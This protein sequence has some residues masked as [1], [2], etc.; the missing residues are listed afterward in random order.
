MLTDHATDV[1]AIGVDIGVASCS[2]PAGLA[3]RHVQTRSFPSDPVTGVIA[4]SVHEGDFD[5]RVKQV[6]EVS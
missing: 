5:A 4:V 6:A 3:I 2:E 1:R